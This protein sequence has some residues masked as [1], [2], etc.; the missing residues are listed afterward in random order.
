MANLCRTLSQAMQERGNEIR[1]F[2]PR[3]GCIN[4]YRNQLHEVIRLSGMNLIINDNDHQLIIKVAS[5]PSARVQIYFIDNDDCFSRKAVLVDDKGKAFEDNDER[6][7]FFARGVLET[8]KK[9]RWEPSIVHCHGWFSSIVPIYLREVFSDDPIFKDVKIVA[10]IYG[11]GFEGE[12]DAEMRHKIE[13]EGVDGK[14]L[15]II[16]RPS[17]QNLMKLV[18]DYADGI[19]VETPELDS[20]IADYLAA[21]GKRVLEY[22]DKTTTEYLDNY[23]KFYDELL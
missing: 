12:L 7:I 3:Y 8:V 17:Y 19:I 20:E 16:E 11:E 18:I 21:S 5:I 2:M 1:T 6:A 23:Q 22:Q 9:L 4:E 14:K 10:S 13:N 15:E